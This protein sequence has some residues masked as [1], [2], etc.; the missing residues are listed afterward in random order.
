MSE[1]GLV[2]I[3][4]H[5]V[6]H[7][8]LDTLGWDDQD[9]QLRQSQLDIARITGKIP[10]VLSYPSGCRNG[11]TLKLAPEY[12]AFGID[13]NGGT[14]HIEGG[15]D[16]FKVDRIYVSRYTTIGEFANKVS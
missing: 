12:Y 6:D 7:F 5:T 2:D 1:S 15:S 16:N 11:S 3:Q 14:W 8:D 9:Y 4:S 13:M 10:Y